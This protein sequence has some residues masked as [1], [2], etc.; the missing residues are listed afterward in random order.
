MKTLIVSGGNKP[1][2]EILE[3]YIKDSDFIIGVDGGCRCLLDKN[4]MPNYIVGDFDSLDEEDVNYLEKCGSIR[5]QYSSDKDFT[6]S[7]IAVNLALENNSSSIIFLGATGT[8]FDHTLANIGLMFKAKLKGVD[9]SIIDNTNK[10]FMIDSSTVI[11]RNND[12]KYISFLAFKSDVV[13]LD[14]KGAKYELNG[15]SL[16]VGDGRT[17]SNEF[18]DDEIVIKFDSGI[19]IVIYSKD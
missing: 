12:Y 19:L 11:E 17:V 15:F 18:L 16:R 6:D 7:E 3:L 10:I 5:R 13:N 14:I 1:N 9:L 8:R 2:D 4:I